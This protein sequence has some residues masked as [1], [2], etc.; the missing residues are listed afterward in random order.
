MSLKE[1]SIWFR[2]L[3]EVDTI[4]EEAIEKIPL[5]TLKCFN[6][7]EEKRLFIKAI[8]IFDKKRKSWCSIHLWS[9]VQEKKLL[10]IST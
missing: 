1:A 7:R 5:Q 3:A 9:F 4:S 10:Y 2:N 8:F 6:W